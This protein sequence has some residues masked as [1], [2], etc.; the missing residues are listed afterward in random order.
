MSVD[1]KT[2]ITRTIPSQNTYSINITIIDAV[3]ITM[4]VLVFDVEYNT[5]SHVATVYDMESYPADRAVAHTQGLQF[6][7]ARGVTRTFSD[8]SAAI[9]FE[10]VTVSRLKQLTIDWAK[11][12]E[13]F[14]S[15]QY[16]TIS[17]NPTVV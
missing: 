11:R 9:N 6:Y 10:S 12:T 13:S 8:V 16:L 4:D 7:R 2:Y 3:N 5:F 14:S 1:I 17:S 15:S